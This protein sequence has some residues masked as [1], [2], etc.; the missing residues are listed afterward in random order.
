VLRDLDLL[1]C[2]RDVE[3]GFT[4]ATL[5]EDV[6]R[7]FEPCSPPVSAR[8]EALAE[9]SEAGIKTWAFYGPLLPLLSDDE[10]QMDALCRPYHEALMARARMLA[11]K[12]SLAL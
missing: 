12:H 7:V 6:R 3:V 8:L 9:L 5:A 4:I 10:K 2:L 1:H 11:E